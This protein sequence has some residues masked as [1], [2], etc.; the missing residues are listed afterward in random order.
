M[1]FFRIF[2]VYS[3]LFSV[4]AVSAPLFDATYAEWHSLLKEVSDVKGSVTNVDY[5]ALKANPAKLNSVLEKLTAVSAEEFSK[6]K[7]NERL[8]FYINAY[9]AFTVKLIVDHYPVKSIKNIGGAFKKPW[10]IRF[11][12][13]LGQKRTLDELE[14]GIIRKQFN[15]P[16]IHLALVCA[17]KACPGLRPYTAANLDPELDKASGDFLRDPTRNRYDATKHELT[18]A[19][20]FD[21]YGD[22]FKKKFSSVPLF[23]APY[24]AN[25]DKKLES[26][27]KSPETKVS[28]FDYDWS[29]NKK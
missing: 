24:L 27:I 2:L 25:G 8:A 26:E 1:K 11:F 17:A 29:L 22:D 9:N 15:E 16:R 19:K 4:S 18:L 6:F 5:D 23:V 20:I 10:D 7:E 21:W 14:H 12:T 28:Y 13:L 3:L